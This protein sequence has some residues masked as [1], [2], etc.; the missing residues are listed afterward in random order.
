MKTA[1]SL[2][3][4]MALFL[5]LATPCFG[6]DLPQTFVTKDG[7]TIHLP[8][9]WKPIPKEV[10]DK[11]SQA[12][13]KMAPKAEKQEYDYGFQRSD[14]KKWFSYPYILVQVKRT[15]RIP[16][17]QLKALKRIKKELDKS[18]NKATEALSEISSNASLGEPV[19]D[20]L[21]H[22]LWSRITIDIK[23]TGTVRGIIGTILTKEGFVQI[24]C[25]AKDD[26]F[27]TYLPVFE[28][29]IS[30][31]EIR[32]SLRYGAENRAGKTDG[33]ERG[34]EAVPWKTMMLV[35]IG[36][37]LLFFGWRIWKK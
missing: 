23:G 29:T 5:F 9:G 2:P 37:L 1:V 18:F 25:Y 19:Y 21:S 4:F 35:L 16:E 27:G 28:S 24:A 13:A 30:T 11:Y 17:V 31:T 14:T 10:L 7:F 32:S 33:E 20:P 8:K 6:L 3:G 34:P 22:I 26:E 36:T 15:G 12:I